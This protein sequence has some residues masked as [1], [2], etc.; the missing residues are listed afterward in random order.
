MNSNQYSWNKTLKFSWGHIIAFIALIFISYITYIGEV[1][2]NGG[3][4]QTAALTVAIIDVILLLLFLSVQFL[5]GTESKFKRSIVLERILILLSPIVFIVCM[6]PYNHFWNVFMQRDTIESQFKSTMWE[7]KEIFREYDSYAD[8]RIKTFKNEI[9]KSNFSSNKSNLD[10]IIKNNYIH[11]LTLQLHNKN[12]ENLKE[13]AFKWIDDNNKDVSIW[14]P[15]LIGNLDEI[16]YANKYWYTCLNEYSEPRLSYEVNSFAN[17]KKFKNAYH[18]VIQDL[19]ALKKI[20][21]EASGYT[22]ISILSALFLFLMLLFP[23]C[24]QRRNTRASG[25]Y[26]LI[27]NC[28]RKKSPKPKEINE[29]ESADIANDNKNKVDN[30]DLY[31]GTF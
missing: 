24:I 4:F 31:S 20:Y 6:K 27:P 14:N 21:K 28:F 10:K 7:S 13:S 25:I 16:S 30:K 19:N 22:T 29:V 18:K 2:V 12:I 9:S 26:H 8:S 17:S 5:K 1:F 23:Y 15:F 3:D 11:T